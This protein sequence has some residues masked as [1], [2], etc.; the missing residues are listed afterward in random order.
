M[1]ENNEYEII[2]VNDGSTDSSGDVLSEYSLKNSSLKIIN[3][4]NRGVSVARNI[5]LISARGK[6]VWFIDPD[7]YCEAYAV[8]NVISIMEENSLEIA[9]VGFSIVNEGAHFSPN[10]SLK[11]EVMERK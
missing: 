2:C 11:M 8:R 6:Y 5:G 10:A 3:Q 9:S 1:G 7:D 4:V